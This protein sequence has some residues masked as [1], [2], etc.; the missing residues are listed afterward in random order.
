[1]GAPGE[2]CDVEGSGV[3][4]TDSCEL[5]AMC[6]DVDPETLEGVCV[7]FCVGSADNPV[8]EDANTSCAINGDGVLAL[9]L[10]SCDPLLQDCGEGQLCAPVADAFSCV[11]DASGDMGAPGDPCEFINVCDPGMFCAST[12]LVPGCDGAGA[13]CCTAFCDLG[14]APPA[15]LPG[16]ECT[17]WYE[18]GNAPP[19]HED[20]GACALP[21]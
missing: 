18:P 13:G 11:P 8:C 17:P 5:G 19:G 1:M 21:T 10:P 6:W 12:E 20:L 2:P 14:E 7:A 9:C 15:C 16:Q 3:S 4:G